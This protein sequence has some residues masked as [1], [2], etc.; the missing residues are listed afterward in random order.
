MKK[1]LAQG[2]VTNETIIRHC[3]IHTSNTIIHVHKVK[4]ENMCIKGKHKTL[5][6]AQICK[7]GYI[8]MQKYT[9]G[10]L[11]Y[12]NRKRKRRFLRGN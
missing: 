10:A 2:A 12:G 6:L 9:Q 4:T 8:G 11:A 5:T 7:Y 3:Y 1:K